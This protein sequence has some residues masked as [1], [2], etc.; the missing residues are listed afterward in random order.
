VIPNDPFV[1]ETANVELLC[2]KMNSHDEVFV[3]S[4]QVEMFIKSV[5]KAQCIASKK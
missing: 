2:P 5:M 4:F 1:D 3:I